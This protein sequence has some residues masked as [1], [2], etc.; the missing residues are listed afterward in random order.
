[1]A[2]T[3]GILVRRAVIEMK[4]GEKVILKEPELHKSRQAYVEEKREEYENYKKCTL[5]YDKF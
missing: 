3:E 2:V 1:M 5:I 4:N